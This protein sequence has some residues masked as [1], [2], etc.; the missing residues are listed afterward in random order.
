[1]DNERARTLIEGIVSGDPEA[2]KAFFAGFRE[3]VEFFVKLKIG[4]RNKDWQDLQQEIFIAL[5][6]RIRAGDY[7]HRKGSVGAFIHST[8]KFKIMDYLKSRYHRSQAL[9]SELTETHPC[10]SEEDPVAL[11]INA[12]QITLFDQALKE[13][14][15]PHRTILVSF[16]YKG[17]KI[18]EIAAEMGLDEQKT[19]NY[20]SYALSL[21]KRRIL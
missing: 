1:M 21:L 10:P 7:D 12:E 2:E 20:K 3:E 16:F 11:L 19:S 4:K 6:R 18:K 15:E 5:F 13:L 14:P 17:L 9:H 8:M